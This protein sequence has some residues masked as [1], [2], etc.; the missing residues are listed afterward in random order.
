VR[1]SLTEFQPTVSARAVGYAVGFVVSKYASGFSAMQLA[2]LCHRVLALSGNVQGSDAVVFYASNWLVFNLVS[3]VLIGFFMYPRWTSPVTL[4]VWV[5]FAVTLGRKVLT[6]PQSVFTRDPTAGLRH[7][8]TMGCS[9][10]FAT[11]LKCADQFF[12]SLPFYA[13]V[14]FSAG[15]LLRLVYDHRLIS[16]TSISRDSPVLPVVP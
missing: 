7:F 13:S 16:R 1:E 9:E 12:Y 2:V 10:S 4:F 15:V 8:L 14:G 11:S 3:G 5:P 6:Y